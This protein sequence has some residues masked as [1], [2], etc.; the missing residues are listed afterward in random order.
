MRAGYYHSP[1]VGRILY[2]VER[3]PSALSRSIS[4]RPLWATPRVILCALVQSGYPR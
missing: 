4:R 1:T 3:I 2:R